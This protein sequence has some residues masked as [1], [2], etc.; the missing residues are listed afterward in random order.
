MDW[1]EIAALSIV[2][3]VWLGWL[4]SLVR[5]HRLGARGTPACRGC[6]PAG[7]QPSTPSVVAKA[8]RGQ[9]PVLI[10]KKR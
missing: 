8:R 6:C 3:A 4:I 2:A 1:Q 5:R 9:E 10:F 7:Q